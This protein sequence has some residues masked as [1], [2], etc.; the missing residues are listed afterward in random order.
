MT[1]VSPITAAPTG[2][3]TTPK[4]KATTTPPLGASEDREKSSQSLTV[5]VVPCAIATLF[6]LVI[7]ATVVVRKRHA[8]KRVGLTTFDNPLYALQE[9]AAET[10]TFTTA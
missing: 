9:T 3:G 10:A 5:I 1:T 8:L 4:A 2:P 6:I 7:V